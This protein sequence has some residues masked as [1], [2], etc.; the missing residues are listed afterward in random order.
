MFLPNAFRYVLIL[1]VITV[2]A[3]GPVWADPAAD[4]QSEAPVTVD[5]RSGRTFSAA[6]DRRTT[7]EVLW[8]RWQQGAASVLRPI[9]WDRVE[10]VRAGASSYDGGTF[11]RMVE[12]VRQELASEQTAGSGATKAATMRSTTI[13]LRGS[14]SDPGRDEGAPAPAGPTTGRPRDAAEVAALSIDARVANWDADV[15]VDGLI[16]EVRPLDASGY[17]V[18]V[19]GTLETTLIGIEDSIVRRKDPF[20]RI[21]R[22]VESVHPEDFGGHGDSFARPA[23]F[24][25][26]FRS[27]HP[28][29]DH[30]ILP[31]AA[32]NARLSVPGQGV[33]E[34]T[35]SSVR[36]QPYSAVRD[37]R[38]QRRG[39]RF[40]PIERNS[41]SGG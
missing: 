28:E 40:F 21:G 19:R 36:I 34:A 24:K 8:L 25:L 32:L 1:L 16:V 6:L 38:Q 39:D 15:E 31:K 26:P 2:G 5:L 14:E 23:R 37:Y 13:V 22:W 29:F 35:E 41:R 10:R 30:N 27:I 11:Q 7:A 18:P 9:A 17:L 33:F 4:P 3:V 12:Q 20:V